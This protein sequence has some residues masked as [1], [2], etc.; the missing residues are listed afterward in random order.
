MAVQQLD[1]SAPPELASPQSRSVPALLVPVA[2]NS[3]PAWLAGGNIPGLDGL[4]ALS[5]AAVVLAHA[6]LTWSGT[7]DHAHPLARLGSIGVDLFFVISGFLITWLLLREQRR[8]AVISLRAFYIR[9]AWRILPPY[10]VFL[11]SLF[12]FSSIGL[13]QITSRDWG[14]ALTYTVN[15]LPGTSWPFGH[16]WSL[17]VEEHFYLFWPLLLIVLGPGRAVAL[18][19]MYILAGPDR[20]DCHGLRAR[21]SG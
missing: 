7:T 16:L 8:N 13:I 6:S 2:E 3:S 12:A 21:V 10:L 11:A 18:S 9:R 14:G 15:F 4:R 5:I 20:H 19:F 1:R 17:S